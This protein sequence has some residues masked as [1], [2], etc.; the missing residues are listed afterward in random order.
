MLKKYKV[1]QIYTGDNHSAMTAVITI[2]DRSFR[3]PYD[4]F[5]G[6]TRGSIYSYKLNTITPIVLFNQFYPFKTRKPRMIRTIIKRLV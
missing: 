3:W 2:N 6:Y 1:E 4:L 5:D